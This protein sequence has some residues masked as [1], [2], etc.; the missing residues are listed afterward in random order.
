MLL[1]TVLAGSSQQPAP[2][3]R[4]VGEVTR[5]FRGDRTLVNGFVRVPHRMLSG[6]TLGISNGQVLFTGIPK[7][8]LTI[9]QGHAFGLGE[10]ERQAIRLSE[11]R[12]AEDD[13]A[14]PHRRREHVPGRDFDRVE[15]NEVA[16]LSP[17]DVGEAERAGDE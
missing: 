14:Q 9:G 1:R 16:G 17:H 2:E 5:F 4:V 8:I 6:V 15:Q 13:E 10:I 7:L 12:D 11:C 3:T